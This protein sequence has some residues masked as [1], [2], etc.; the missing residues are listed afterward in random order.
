[1][2]CTSDAVR[3]AFVQ[4]LQHSLRWGDF[5]SCAVLCATVV[6]QVFWA[7]WFDMVL[8]YIFQ[9]TL[10]QA[11]PA[12][13]KFVPFFGLAGWLMAGGTEQDSSSSSGS[14]SSTQSS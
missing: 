12:Q 10:M 13:F 14:S 4:H 9:L 2:H 7:F 5:M 11:A 3:M 6:L 8:F 1:M